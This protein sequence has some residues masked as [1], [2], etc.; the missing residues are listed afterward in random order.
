MQ[1]HLGTDMIIG[2]GEKV[3]RPH[4]GF[5]CTEG[6]FDRTLTHKH[7]VRHFRQLSL[8]DFEHVFMLPSSDAPLLS[9]CAFVFQ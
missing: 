7:S 8:H 4:P 2:P 9:R 6:M 3:R 1:A 5:D